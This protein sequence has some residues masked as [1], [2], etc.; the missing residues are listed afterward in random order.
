MDFVIIPPGDLLRRLRLIHGKAMRYQ[1]Y[2]WV[3]E[4][5][6]CWEARDLPRRSQEQIVDGAYRSE[7]RDFS[8]WLNAWAPIDRL[9][10]RGR[11]NKPLKRMVGRRRP[12]TA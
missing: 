9:G 3:T 6:Q 7:E 12:P 4:D 10:R 11:S 5:E 1:T 8:P 2:L